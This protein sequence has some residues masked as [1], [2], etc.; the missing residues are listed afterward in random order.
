MSSFSKDPYNFQPETYAFP[1]EFN[2]VF[3]YKIKQYLNDIAIALNAKEN[4]FYLDIETPATPRFLPLTTSLT[5]SQN[6]EDRTLFRKVVDFGALPNT[7]TKTVAHGI[8]TTENY[9]LIHLYGGATDP[10]VSTLTSGLAL[11]FASPV[12]VN[13]ISLEIDATN[14]IITTGSNRTAYT[15]TFIVIEYIKEV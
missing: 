4:G 1:E 8:T 5:G 11:P 14:V 6:F 10:G 15:R 13:N 3:V 2:D 12:L 7:A 9:C